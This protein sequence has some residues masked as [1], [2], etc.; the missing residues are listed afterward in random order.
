[1]KNKLLTTAKILLLALI[2]TTFMITQSQ[3]QRGDAAFNK[4]DKTIGVSL[5]AGVS[6]GYTTYGSGRYSSLPAIA[7]TYDQ[8]FFEDIGPGNIGIG[9]IIGFKSSTYKYDYLTNNGT[10]KFKH[11]VLF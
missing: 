8:C 4:G 3:A 10:Y 11:S 9:G 1:M 6:Y 2:A 7:V 5:G